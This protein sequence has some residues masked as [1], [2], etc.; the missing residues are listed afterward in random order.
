MSDAH[1]AHESHEHPPVPYF[2]IAGTLF[3]LTLVTIAVSFVNLGKTGNVVLALAV[4]TF[5]GSLVMT[6]FMHLKYERKIMWVIALTPFALA[7]VLF[8]A[9]FPDV[10]FGQ[11]PIQVDKAK[12]EHKAEKER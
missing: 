10:V 8:F 2:L 3:V 1:A 4:A 5:K 9:L 12:T 6:F 7:G 11:Y